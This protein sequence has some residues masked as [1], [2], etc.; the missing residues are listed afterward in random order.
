METALDRI[1]ALDND[2]KK[3]ELTAET[4]DVFAKVELTEDEKEKLE[5]MRAES[6]TV[7]TEK[8]AD[9]TS[10][11]T[12]IEEYAASLDNRVME[13][14]KE[15][16]DATKLIKAINQGDIRET[17]SDIQRETREKANRTINMIAY[18]NGN[19]LDVETVA[20]MNDGAIKAVMDYFNMSKIDSA[21]ASKK[22]MKMPATQVFKILPQDFVE[23]YTST[24][25]REKHPDKAKEDLVTMFAYLATSGPEMDYLNEFIDGE[26]KLM[27]VSQELVQC[28]MDINKLLESDEKISEIVAKAN[29]IMPRDKSV[30][31]RYI[32][33][34]PRRLHDE[35]AQKA[36]IYQEYHAGYSAIME[37]YKDESQETKDLIQEQLDE[38]TN[39]YNV[40]TSVTDLT[41]FKELWPILTERLKS[42]RRTDYVHLIRLAGDAVE[43]VRR[44]KLDLPFPGYDEKVAKNGEALF[45]AYINYFP[46]MLNQYNLMI[47]KVN[48]LATEEDRVELSEFP[49]MKVELPGIQDYDVFEYFSI[50]LLIQFGR[51]VKKL[52]RPL[53]TKYDAIELDAYFTCFCKMGTDIY[54]MSDIWNICKEF[55]E[56]AIK[57][58]PR[59][60]AP[61]GK[62]R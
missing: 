19:N 33:N 9:G 6:Q 11:S 29:E 2:L 44:C 20:A 25:E 4:P 46:K 45:S 48:E 54:L 40:Y 49:S 3:N 23:T 12:A 52:S 55:V 56:Y 31:S 53:A 61:R 5:Q 30:W 38:C 43:R 34:D 1:M 28:Q 16:G 15:A 17:V 32:K 7:V 22:L 37:K 26:H 18:A 21:V 62:K 24:E 27:A 39:K 60:K 14:K 58:W 57:T 36:I 8:A 10:I 51:I 35:F 59:K 13:L 50:L 47:D 42:D 41:T